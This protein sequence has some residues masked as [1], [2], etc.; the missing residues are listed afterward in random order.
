MHIHPNTTIPNTEM[1]SLYAA[2]QAAAKREVERTRNKLL[3]FGYEVEAGSESEEACIVQL[4][5]EP[6]NHE[7]KRRS[8]NRKRT[9]ENAETKPEAESVSD[10][11]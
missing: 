9:R 8:D 7:Q 2:Q 6:E 1:N 3:G 5:A 4:N 10:W 11:A